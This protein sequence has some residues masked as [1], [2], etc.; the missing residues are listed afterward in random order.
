MCELKTTHKNNVEQL[1]RVIIF[2]YEKTRHQINDIKRKKKMIYNN[3]YLDVLTMFVTFIDGWKKKNDK[4]K[5]L[6]PHISKQASLIKENRCYRKQQQIHE[7]LLLVDHSTSFPRCQ[8]H[9]RKTLTAP[10]FLYIFTRLKFLLFTKIRVMR[11]YNL[12]KGK[13]W[14]RSAF[15]LLKTIL[16]TI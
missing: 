6:P 7:R 4:R 15:S 2:P 8:K 11:S 13:G 1:K 5:K 3:I 10:L 14:R 12:L 9:K 16:F